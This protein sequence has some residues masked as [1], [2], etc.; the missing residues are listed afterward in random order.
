MSR[1][2]PK[3][4]STRQYHDDAYARVRE[5]PQTEVYAG[6]IW[7]AAEHGYKPAYAAVKFREI[8]HAWPN[9]MELIPAEPPSVELQEWFYRARERRS[10]EYSRQKAKERKASGVGPHNG[11]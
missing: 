11:P 6:L 10:A 2:N 1:I 8:F 9:G 4:K 7:I 3:L 5:R